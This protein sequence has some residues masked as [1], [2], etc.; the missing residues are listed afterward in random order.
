MSTRTDIPRLSP[1]RCPP[2]SRLLP[3]ALISARG[4]HS[5]IL[6]PNPTSCRQLL[7][8]PLLPKQCLY[9]QPL[10]LRVKSWASLPTART[11]SL[12]RIYA[13]RPRPQPS[14]RLSPEIYIATSKGSTRGKGKKENQDASA[15]AKQLAGCADTCLALVCD[16]HGECGHLVSAYLA[17]HLPGRLSQVIGRRYQEVEKLR[18][19]IRT[20]VEKVHEEVINMQ[21]FRAERSGST[22]LAVA[23]WD[24]RLIAVNVGDSRATVISSERNVWRSKQ[25]TTDHK[26]D[27]AQERERIEGNSGRVAA[28]MSDT[29]QLLGPARVWKAAEAIPGLAMSRSIGDSLAHSI[30]VSATPDVTILPIRP[31]DKAIVLAS[32]GHCGDCGNWLW[33]D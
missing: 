18:Q 29:G 11:S 7:Q 12:L 28:Y 3:K 32:D 25:I 2:L 19:I 4:S 33:R 31:V 10:H 21:E 14:L 22:L 13:S 30:G 1:L 26:P 16:G 6:H 24:N 5:P 27:L 17:K 9:R 23:V 15:V 8:G 20:E